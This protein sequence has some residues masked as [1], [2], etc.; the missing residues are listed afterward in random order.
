LKLPQQKIPVA[1]QKMGIP[2][3]EQKPVANLAGR[4]TGINQTFRRFQHFQ[5]G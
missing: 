3:R 1:G 4:K 5:S 2:Q